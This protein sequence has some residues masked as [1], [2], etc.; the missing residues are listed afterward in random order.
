[1]FG[2]KS[3]MAKMLFDEVYLR[4]SKIGII[5]NES[6]NKQLGFFYLFELSYRVSRALEF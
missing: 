5:L 2:F 6:Y 1:M 3:L 4:N